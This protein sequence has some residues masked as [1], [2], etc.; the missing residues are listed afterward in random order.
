MSESRWDEVPYDMDD[1]HRDLGKVK[2]LLNKVDKLKKKL[3]VTKTVR[4]NPKPGGTYV[5]RH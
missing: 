2:Y 4:V 1:Y 5:N 3:V